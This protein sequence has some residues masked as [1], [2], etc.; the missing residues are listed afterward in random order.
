MLK[1]K[2]FALA[3]LTFLFTAPLSAQEVAGMVEK[4]RGIATAT[5]E[6]GVS[7]LAPG[8]TV[9]V[10][11]SLKTESRARLLIKFK[12]G[13]R[14]TLGENALI[15]VDDLLYQPDTDKQSQTIDVVRGV[16]SF[17]SGSIAKA[18]YSNLTFRTPVATIGIRGTEFLG[19]ELTVGMAAGR[20]HYGFQIYDGAIEVQAPGGSVVLDEPGEGTFLPLTRIAAPTP[21]R[22]WTPEEAAE[23]QEALAF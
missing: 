5:N 4:I 9:Y 14:L 11:D 2:I 13:S 10:D 6:T 17:V 18:N 19:G 20:P 7:E 22:Q 12:D 21:V 8:S 1:L 3:L 16:F 23:A 15:I